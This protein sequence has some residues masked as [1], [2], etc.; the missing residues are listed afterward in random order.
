METSTSF[1]SKK[2]LDLIREIHRRKVHE[3]LDK[4]NPPKERKKA[5]RECRICGKDFEPE[6]PFVRACLECKP[7]RDAPS[8]KSRAKTWRA[9]LK[10]HFGTEFFTKEDVHTF[11]KKEYSLETIKKT[12]YVLVRNEALGLKRG[13]S[14][15]NRNR[16]FFS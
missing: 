16:Y 14:R 1:V 12:L 9:L 13:D 5:Q 8:D 3:A 10:S 7:E 4:E 15:F 2:R 11:F 6:N